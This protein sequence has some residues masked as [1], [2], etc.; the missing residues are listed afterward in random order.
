MNKKSFL[1]G[2]GTGV[3]FAAIILGISC[4]IRTSDVR[5]ISQA[6]KLGMDFVK[7]DTTVVENNRNKKDD[8]ATAAPNEKT[9]SKK[10]ETKSTDIPA[11]T[12]N[13]KVVPTPEPDDTEKKT[14]D[15][16]SDKKSSNSMEAEK[17]KMEKSIKDEAKQLE[18]KAGDWSSTVSSKLQKMGI[19]ENATD[20]DLYLMQNGYGESIAAGTYSVSPDDT[21]RELAR[22]ITG[23]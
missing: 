15:K 1:R 5:V 3:L 21:Y 22:K 18:I 13:P 2:F 4:L 9:D 19:I 11:E 14:T 10:Q 16:K 7:N 6:K 20:F 8:A 12:E 17:N 23:K